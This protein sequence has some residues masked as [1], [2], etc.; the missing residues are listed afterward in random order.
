MQQLFWNEKNYLILK[1]NFLFEEI[2]YLVVFIQF[3]K[4]FF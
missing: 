2:I 4:M 3:N 1:C